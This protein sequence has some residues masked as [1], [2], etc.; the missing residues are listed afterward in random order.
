MTCRYL[1]G[2]TTVLLSYWSGWWNKQVSG[3]GWLVVLVAT[4]LLAARVTA[5]VARVGGAR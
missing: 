1:L 5:Q 4:V 2:I 3:L